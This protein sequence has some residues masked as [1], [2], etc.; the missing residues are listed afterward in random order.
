RGRRPGPPGQAAPP[1]RLHRR[2]GARR[3]AGPRGGERAALADG[4]G[5]ACAMRRY[6]VDTPRS[7]WTG[8]AV[9]GLGDPLEEATVLGRPLSSWHTAEPAPDVIK[10][11]A[12]VIGRDLWVSR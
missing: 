11:P 10:G 5:A 7:A 9:H 8:G 12:L 4:P 2:R 1:A 6:V 3:R